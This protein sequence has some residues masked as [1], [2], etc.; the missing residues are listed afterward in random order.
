M[1]NIKRILVKDYSV[2]TGEEKEPDTPN[3]PSATDWAIAELN[4]VLITLE[5]DGAYGY[6][7]DL[8]QAKQR[9][10]QIIAKTLRPF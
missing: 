2:L 3:E 6:I 1:S 4:N 10:D 5:K 9:I 8:K 7:V